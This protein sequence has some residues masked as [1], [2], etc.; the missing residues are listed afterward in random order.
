MGPQCVLPGGVQLYSEGPSSQDPSSTPRSYPIVLTGTWPT[1]CLH[2]FVI[3]PCEEIDVQTV[4]G[5]SDLCGMLTESRILHQVDAS[6][7]VHL[8]SNIRVG[9]EELG[10][11]ST[12]WMMTGTLLSHL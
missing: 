4:F 9:S 3:V 12:M 1:F 8:R 11:Q 10:P 6:N 7:I 2:F 5:H